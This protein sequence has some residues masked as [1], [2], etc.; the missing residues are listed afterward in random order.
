MEAK[1]TIAVFGASGSTGSTITKS[2]AR[3]TYRK[4]FKSFS[5]IF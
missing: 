1:Q 4:N 3:G 5:R 2:I